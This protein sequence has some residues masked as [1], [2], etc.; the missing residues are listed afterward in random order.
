MVAYG[1]LAAMLQRYVKPLPNPN[2]M[3]FKSVSVRLESV[4][5]TRML[6]GSGAV[7]LWGNGVSETM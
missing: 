6:A 3:V 2:P 1:A 4:V 5:I 7:G